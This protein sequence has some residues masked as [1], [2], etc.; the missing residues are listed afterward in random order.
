MLQQL[1]SDLKRIHPELQELYTQ[2][3]RG[4]QVHQPSNVQL[5]DT[6][7]K[8]IQ[9]VTSG[10][11]VLDA[12]DECSEGDRASVLTWVE[13]ISTKIPIAV[14]SRHFPEGQ[15]ANTGLTIALDN[16]TEEDI[17]LFLENQMDMH[18]K[19]DL[20]DLVLNTLKAKAQGQ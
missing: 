8:I 14:T 17:A 2:C 9:Q 11:I 1:G 10:W 13:W 15:A 20:K 4:P 12:M 18:F 5:E 16:S 3:K 7:T 6:L 19:G